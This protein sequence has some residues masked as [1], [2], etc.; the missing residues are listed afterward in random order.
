[1]IAEG[2]TL[3]RSI[4]T[5]VTFVN[6]G[7][8]L[9]MTLNISS[10]MIT[11]EDMLLAGTNG[12]HVTCILGSFLPSLIHFTTITSRQLFSIPKSLY[13]H[14]H[15]YPLSAFLKC[16]NLQWQ[17]FAHPLAL[18]PSARSPAPLLG[19]AHTPPWNP[20]Q[21][22]ENRCRIPRLPNQKSTHPPW[23]RIPSRRKPRPRP[24]T[25]TDGPRTDQ[26]KSP[27]CKHTLWI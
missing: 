23:R 9:H 12:W 2:I 18:R 22:W 20:C 15:S 13:R 14:N 10:N 16:Y 6:L 24:S 3:Y 8:S 27:R 25:S 11:W 26:L 5:S 21:N 1:M 7:F 19:P 17:P 4:S